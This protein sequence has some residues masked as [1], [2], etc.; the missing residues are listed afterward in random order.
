MGWSGK[1]SSDSVGWVLEPDNPSMRYWALQD[2]LGKKSTDPDVEKALDGVMQTPEVQSILAELKPGGWWEN[3]NDMYLPKYRAST[4]QLLILAELGAKRIP[5]I[6]NAIEHL[7]KFQRDS[8]HFLT[9][10]PKTDKGRASIVMD[11][12]CLDGNVLF[13]LNH[14]G[15]IDDE[16]TRQL[17]DFT[18]KYHSIEKGGWKCRSYPINPN[19]V[20][21]VNCYMGATKVLKA[22]SRIQESKRS[23]DIQAI[24]EREIENILENQIFRYLRNKDGSRKDKEGWK[25][26][27]FPLFYQSDALEVLDTL[28]RLGVK[29]ERMIPAIELVEKAQGEDGTWRLMN[30]FNGKMI[31]DIEEK[32]KPSKWITLKA[33]RVLKGFYF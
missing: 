7:F 13:Y 11:G 23:K 26:F 21:P 14:F 19:S 10:L 8:G 1:L 9:E 24:I 3:E 28:V 32:G 30:T 6:E 4:H 20:F 29:D 17:L 22:F 5:S 15:F 12:C 2:L 33:C 27:G 16:R 25:R 31:V 18:V